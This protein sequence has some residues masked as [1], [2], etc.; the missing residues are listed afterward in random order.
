VVSRETGRPG[1]QLL[2]SSHLQG[3]RNTR[4]IVYSN[5]PY[6]EPDLTSRAT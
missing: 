1:V 3:S 2:W 6:R 5:P 4:T